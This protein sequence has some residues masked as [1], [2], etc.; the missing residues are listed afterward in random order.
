MPVPWILWD[1]FSHD[2]SH[3]AILE[4]LFCLNAGQRFVP[5]ELLGGSKRYFSRN[6]LKWKKCREIIKH[7]KKHGDRMIEGIIC[8]KELKY[9]P[10]NYHV[11]P[12]NHLFWSNYSDLTRP[13]PP[14]GSISE[15]KWDPKFQGNL[16]EGE[17]LFHLARSL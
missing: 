13:G 2:H 4:S 6:G 14:K 9:T 1:I 12:E 3:L 17:I 8:F 16:G 5:V 11:E 7:L 15:G 10:E